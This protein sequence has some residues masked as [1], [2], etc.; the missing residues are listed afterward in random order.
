M[1]V[2]AKDAQ[3]CFGSLARR[4]APWASCCCGPPG[5]ASPQFNLFGLGPKSKVW[6]ASTSHRACPQNH[7]PTFLGFCTKCAKASK[8]ATAILEYCRSGYGVGGFVDKAQ[9]RPTASALGL[10]LVPLVFFAGRNIRFSGLRPL[11]LSS[12]ARSRNSRASPDGLGLGL[13]T[14]APSD[15]SNVAAGA[16]NFARLDFL[17]RSMPRGEAEASCFACV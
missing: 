1:R 12:F 4:L 2:C 11:R 10:G 13:R 5:S 17:S 16:S 15:Q 3:V 6:R 7:A 9:S 8:T 14:V